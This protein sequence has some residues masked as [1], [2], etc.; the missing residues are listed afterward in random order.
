MKKKQDKILAEMLKLVPFDGWSDTALRT[1]TANL[2]LA[3][4]YEKV[5]FKDGVR[6]AIELFHQSINAETFAKIN[7]DELAEMKVRERIFHIIDTRFSVMD[8]YKPAIRK[9]LQFLAMPQ[10]ICIGTKML[11]DM[12]DGVWYAAGDNSADFNHY[13][14]RA[15]LMAVYSSTLL[16]WLEDESENHSSTSEFLN[17]RLKNV[18]QIGKLKSKIMGMGKKV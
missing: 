5:A 12:A 3:E 2:G 1:A 15:T 7:K 9:T 8:E 18:M 13:T 11:W 17:R 16:F 14:K 6:D 10:N 4:H